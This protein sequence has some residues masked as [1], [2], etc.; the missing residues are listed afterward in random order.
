MKT[1]DSQTYR[2]IRLADVLP[3]LRVD[4][5]GHELHV[6]EC[7]KQVVMKERLII[8]GLAVVISMMIMTIP[9]WG[10]IWVVNGRFY[11]DLDGVMGSFCER[12][13][14]LNAR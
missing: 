7:G 14:K 13:E 5:G 2:C 3:V 1:Y 11:L 6:L 9:V 12:L 8:A 4:A 10:L